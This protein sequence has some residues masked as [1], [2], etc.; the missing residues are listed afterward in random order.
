MK[1]RHQIILPTMGLMAFALAAVAAISMV[2]FRDAL[3]SESK[4]QLKAVSQTAIE[5]VNTWYFE[6][7]AREMRQLAT[8]PDLRLKMDD[9]YL[10]KKAKAATCEK[11]QKLTGGGS[12]YIRMLFVGPDGAVI[13]SSVASDLGKSLPAAVLAKSATDGGAAV[14]DVF[15]CELTAKPSQAVSAVVDGGTDGGGVLGCVVGILDPF[16]QLRILEPGHPG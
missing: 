8:D 11:F 14:S 4:L 2:A 12:A 16:E 7:R 10:G 1:V 6:G 9:S 15:T 5:R 3:L 13:A